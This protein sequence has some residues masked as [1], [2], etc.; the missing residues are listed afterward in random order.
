MIKIEMSAPD[1]PCPTDPRVPQRQG[2]SRRVMIA[3]TA[4]LLTT[5]A[6]LAASPA[7]TLVYIGT[8]AA[9]PGQ[10]VFAA[11]LDSRTGRLSPLGLAAELQRP[12]WLVARPD[13]PVLYAVSEVGNDGKSQGS[14]HTLRADPATGR[15]TVAGTT[16]SGGGGPTHLAL[17]TASKTLLVA[18]YGTGQVAAL[19]VLP[20]GTLGPAASVQ[21]DEG[22]GPN[23]RQKGPHAHGV[24]LDPSRRFA[25]VA[26]LGADRVFVY[27]YDRAS[28]QLSPAAT[29]VEALPPGTGPRHLAFHPNGRLVFL[30]SEL[31][32]ELRTYRWDARR[33]RLVLVQTLSLVGDPTKAGL[34]KGGELA[35]GRDGRFVYVSVRG[36]DALAVFAV[37]RR[38][39]RLSEIQRL[40]A[41]GQAPWSFAI[42]PSGR[43]ML[44]ANQGSGAVVVFARDPASGR[45]SPTSESM[46]VAKPT[47][48]AYLASTGR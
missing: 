32:P 19:P 25:L 3:A 16:P 40:P 37:E 24:V 9:E 36:E 12:T 23:P 8:Q 41:G 43:W 35:V 28:R 2:L 45:L 21:S 14:V 11:R 6:A 4:S 15:L 26:D 27:R 33:G 44:V 46:A 42:N 22:S 31:I 1:S 13:L 34:A 47:S 17:D 18:N 39:G 7:E 48:I 29:P 20:D 5:P 38:T 30:I 10:G